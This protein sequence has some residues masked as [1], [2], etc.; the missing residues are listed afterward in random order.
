ML[1]Y[2]Y[3]DDLLQGPIT[4]LTQSHTSVFHA[5]IIGKGARKSVNTSGNIGGGNSKSASLSKTSREIELLLG[6]LMS[7]MV[8]SMF[9]L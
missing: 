4:Q 8:R 3:A 6:A 1:V 2:V 7:C 5:G 9:M